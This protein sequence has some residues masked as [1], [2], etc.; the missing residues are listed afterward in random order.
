MNMVVF[1]ELRSSFQCW[2][3]WG[4]LEEPMGPGLG[5]SVGFRV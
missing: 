3:G 2:S 5:F 4:F 1:Y